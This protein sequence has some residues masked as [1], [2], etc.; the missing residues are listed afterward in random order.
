VPLHADRGVNVHGFGALGER[1]LKSPITRRARQPLGFGVPTAPAI[2]G[3][4]RRGVFGQ[5]TA[6]SSP[7]RFESNHP[8][9][10]D[11]TRLAA[12]LPTSPQARLEPAR[13]RRK[14]RWRHYLLVLACCSGGGRRHFVVAAEAGANAA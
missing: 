14:L 13:L 2:F 12:T 1:G 4:G 9:A 10:L 3:R 7:R 6:A 5:E 8:A 11:V